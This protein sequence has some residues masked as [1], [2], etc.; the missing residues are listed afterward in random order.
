MGRASLF[1]WSTSFAIVLSSAVGP[2]NATGEGRII[3]LSDPGEIA[4]ATAVNTAIDF[5]VNAAA[6]CRK[7]TSKTPLQCE[8]SSP[9]GMAR[10]RSAYDSAVADHP[11]WPQPNTTVWWSGTAVNFSAIRR[12]LGTCH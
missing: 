6:E 12:V 1:I 11:E 8:C 2:A 4:Q 3:E 9:G 5:L 7:T 10:L